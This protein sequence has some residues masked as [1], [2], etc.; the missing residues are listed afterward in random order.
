MKND[1]SRNT[2]DARR[3]FSGVRMQQGRVQLD[4]DWN[5]QSDIIAHRAETAAADLVGPCG[6]PLHAAAFHVVTDLSQLTDEERAR[7]ENQT[8]PEGYAPPDF[9]L[10]AGRYY[11]DG[12][13]CENESLTSYHHQPDLRDARRLTAEGLYLIY[14]DVWRRHLTALDEPGIREVALGGPDTATRAK[15]VWQVK[16]LFLGEDA[17]ASCLSEFAQYGYLTAPSGG[18]LSART[19]RER[20][21][22]DPCIVPP[23]AGYRGLENQHYRVEIHEGGDALDVAAAGIFAPATRVRNRNDQVVVPGGDWLRGQAVEI[24]SDDPSSDRLNGTLAHITHAADREAGSQT[25]TLNINVSKLALDEMRLRPV[26]ATYKWSRDNGA[27]VTAVNSITN[28]EVTVHDLG[29]D[30]ALGFKEGQWV[31]IT[32]DALELGGRPGQL[33]QIVK[34]DEA[35]NLVTLN[36]APAHL[37]SDDGVNKALHPKLRRWDGVGT[38]KYDPDDAGEGYLDLEGGV[39]VRFTAGT[40]KT[41]DYWNIPARTA[42]ADAQSGNIEWPQVSGAPQELPPFG[43]RHHYCRLALVRSDGASLTVL[44]DCRD[45]FPPVTELT[46]LLYVGGD[47]QEALPGDPLPQ[48]LEV[49]VFNGRWPVA[50]ARVRFDATGNG[51]LAADIAGLATSTDE[52]LIVTTG[53]D[54]IASCAWRLAAPAAREEVR[55]S[56]RPRRPALKTSQ[57]AVARLLDAGGDDLPQVVRFNGQLSIAAQ[58]AY[59][60]GACAALQGQ[61]TVQQAID[62]LSELASLYKLSGDGQQLT[63]GGTL[64]PLRVLL[65]N[66]C[67][68]VTGR[69]A[70]VTF[71]VAS[72]SGRVGDGVRP[73]APSVNITADAEGV[74]TCFWQPDATTA[75]QEVEA[76]VE[77]NAARPTAAPSSVR[78]SATVPLASYVGYAPT[79]DDCP[80][81]AGATT[82][83]EALDR[84][85]SIQSGGGCEVVVGEG[86]E[87]ASLGEALRKLTEE[88]RAGIC[89]CLLPGE[90]FLE[91]GR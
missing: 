5:E 72:G 81:L 87:F 17:E 16:V 32:D 2:F 90:H 22:A 88:R 24:F 55:P 73:P 19:R 41:G 67:G 34:V 83:Q 30:D 10:S 42:T 26:G 79:P 7:P 85:C 49:G 28:N 11:V 52:T 18:R 9:L 56:P 91:A 8:P 60:P 14:L 39:Q 36:F 53:P 4:A 25:L 70:V 1:S 78:F 31:E 35:T 66:R 20:S 37:G 63:P 23:G 82:V 89:I 77:D 12:I 46:T 65:A 48:L 51:R 44:S 64:E 58:V 54:G 45:L 27:V 21:S 69:R 43:I 59:D 33:A 68:K 80:N 75:F 3:H 86:G 29:P 38:V 15:T 71:R 13:L 76:F 47:G 84:L 6:G 40:Y 50:G 74:A 62:R 57:Q 61:T